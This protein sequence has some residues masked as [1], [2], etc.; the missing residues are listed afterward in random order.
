MRLK[1]MKR[2]L[3]LTLAAS[4]CFAPDMAGY[5]AAIPQ[6]MAAEVTPQEAAIDTADSETVTVEDEGKEL[7]LGQGTRATAPAAPASLYA[8]NITWKSADL[9]WSA[10]AGAEGYIVYGPCLS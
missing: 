3:S 10:V 4:M 7:S 1:W 9:H 8:D 6:N 5:A 2:L